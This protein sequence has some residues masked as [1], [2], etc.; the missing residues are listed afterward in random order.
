[1]VIGMSYWTGSDEYELPNQDAT[2][3]IDKGFYIHV[4]PDVPNRFFI[5]ERKDKLII[6]RY[7]NVKLP[8]NLNEFLKMIGIAK[9]T[10]YLTV[11]DIKV[12][13][14]IIIE[15]EVFME[16]QTTSLPNQDA[17]SANQ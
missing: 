7:K 10:E 1:M 17:K 6:I 14:V 8:S 9:E 5:V 15:L 2:S 13:D 4:K 3:D 11:K 12:R 16:W